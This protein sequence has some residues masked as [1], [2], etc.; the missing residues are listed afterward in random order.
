MW[1]AAVAVV[2]LVFADG[3]A[4]LDV[5]GYACAF[6]NKHCYDSK[7]TGC[8]ALAYGT[9]HNV[10]AI[11]TA[12]LGARAT[13]FGMASVAGAGALFQLRLYGDADCRS[14]PL[15]AEVSLHQARL[16]C[17]AFGSIGGPHLVLTGAVI[18]RGFR[19]L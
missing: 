16:R 17:P 10:S 3:G 7:L 4:A 14:S 15:H 12:Q 2:G 18:S 5:R 11:L 19:Q 8:A 13:A 6:S 1:F 9:C